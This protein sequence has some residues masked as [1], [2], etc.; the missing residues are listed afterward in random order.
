MCSSDLGISSNFLQVGERKYFPLVQWDVLFRSYPRY[1][2]VKDLRITEE[3]RD[4]LMDLRPYV[5]NA[6]ITV[7][8]TSSVE[9]R[10]I[11]IP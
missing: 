8:E 6:A 9:V 4:Q 11:V 10:K 7:Q 5:N 1:P 2:D 3:D